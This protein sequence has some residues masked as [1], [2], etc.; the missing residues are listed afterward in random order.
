[1]ASSKPPRKKKKPNHEPRDE[2]YDEERKKRRERE[3]ERRERD[4]EESG[5]EYEIYSSKEG[6]DDENFVV[7]GKGKLDGDV[8]TLHPDLDDK[9]IELRAFEVT[10]Q[11]TPVDIHVHRESSPDEPVVNKE[12]KEFEVGPFAPVVATVGSNVFHGGVLGPGIG[13][14]NV[15]AEN[16]PV[17][18]LIRD[19]HVCGAATPQPH[20]VGLTA[21]LGAPSGV[22][23]NG[24]P[25]A[26]AGDVVVEA[27]GGPNPITSGAFSIQAGPPAPSVWSVHPSAFVT[28]ERD[29]VLTRIGKWFIDSDVEASARVQV[30]PSTESLSAGLEGDLENSAIGANARLDTDGEMLHYDVNID[31]KFEFFGGRLSW[32]PYDNW[33]KGGGVGKWTGYLDIIIDPVTKKPIPKFDVDFGEEG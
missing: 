18:R 22:F 27:G 1:M 4:G 13:S 32:H 23:V 14:P 11:T 16:K 17:W 25:I 6:E 24:F 12:W 3:K 10:S 15:Y 21:T 26:R 8:L 7:L 20:G 33:S 31:M 30:L 28:V 2:E 5:Y 29:G 19:T 9:S